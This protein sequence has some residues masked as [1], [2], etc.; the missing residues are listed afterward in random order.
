MSRAR[1]GRTVGMAPVR[2]SRPLLRFFDVYLAL[3]VRRHFHAVRVAGAEQWRRAPR[4][5][6]VC[7]NH[8]SWWD[9]LTSILLS[10][11]VEKT[12]DHYAPMDE[13]AFARYGILRRLGLFPVEQGTP[14]GGAQFLRAASHI[15]HDANAV[16]WVTPQGGFT[17]VRMRPVVFRAGLD[18][19]LRRMPQ[20]TVLP[21]ALEYTFWD[22]RL[23]EALAMFGEPL[24]FREGKL[25]GGDE[26]KTPGDAAAGG[27]AA[28][29]DA[30]ARL[31]ALRDPALFTPVLAG[32]AGTGGIY[33]GWQ[34]LRAAARGER[35]QAEHGSLGKH[36]SG[37][38]VLARIPARFC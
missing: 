16:L 1:G 25:A 29:Q 7:L 31:A 33:G 27:L 17:D 28:T 35:F 24:L 21:L 11:F 4:P 18:A 30:L 32:G 20:V 2:P 12:A 36:G 34:R 22:E 13:I 23:P 38:G 5:L 3:F 15:L 9:P 8:P 26:Q 14:R 19:L 6:V 10:R 37:P